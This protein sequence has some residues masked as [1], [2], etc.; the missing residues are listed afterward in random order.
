ML[1]VPSESQTAAMLLLHSAIFQHF[2]L[3][4]Q[5]LYQSSPWWFKTFRSIYVA[6]FCYSK[7]KQITLS[8]AHSYTFFPL[9][10]TRQK[11]YLSMRKKKKKKSK[12]KGMGMV[13]T[14]RHTLPP[15]RTAWC[16]DFHLGCEG[17]RGQP[18]S[19]EM[20]VTVNHA[21]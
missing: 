7:T 3:F 9:S 18:T 1:S 14:H 10:A 16:Q 13:L 21:Q 20:A 15:L 4:F 12:T 19:A 2:M 6:G 5:I 17:G 11:L 8:R